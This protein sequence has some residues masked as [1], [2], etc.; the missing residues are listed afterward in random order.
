MSIEYTVEDGIAVVSLNRPD[1]KN[2]ML[3][4]MR[5]QMAGLCER[6]N[7]D[8]AVRVAILT[9]A[10]TDFCAGADVSEMAKGGVD[11]SLFR[12]RHMYKLITALGR[13][14]KPLIGAVRG[15]ALGMGLSM[16]LACDCLLA[17][18]TLRMGCVQRK[19]GLSPD[20]GN[21]W[22]LTRY[23]GV[24]RAKELVFSARM[25]GAQ[26]AL[27]LGLVNRIVI[28]AELMNE[29]RAMARTFA[30]APTLALAAAKRMFDRA[31]A[32]SLDEFME[33]EG[34]LVPLVAQTEDFREGTRAFMEKR[35][36]RFVG[37]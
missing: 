30:D 27:S 8:S 24:A 37:N 32:L 5:D 2:A 13:V 29:A 34:S 11:G 22:F 28:D 7:D 19:I 17:T 23:L 15:V 35:P 14:Q 18:E 9:G 31:P 16:A 26:E 21:V 33:L 6:I 3:L 20:A 4:A 10:G 12:A 36:P 1:K 25:L